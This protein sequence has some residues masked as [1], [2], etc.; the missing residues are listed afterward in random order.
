MKFTRRGAF[1]WPALIAGAAGP[2]RAAPGG[3]PSQNEAA[4]PEA[5]TATRTV[6]LRDFERR[7]SVEH[8]ARGLGIHQ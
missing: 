1:V 8:A 3:E 7:A 5:P 4:P 6:S 2:G